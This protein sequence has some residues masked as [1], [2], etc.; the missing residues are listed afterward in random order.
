MVGKMMKKG[1]WLIAFL[2]VVLVGC[3]GPHCVVDPNWKTAPSSFTVVTTDPF[4]SNEGDVLDDFGGQ[5]GFRQWFAAYLDSAISVSSPLPHSVRVVDDRS[6]A[7]EP[8]Y[9]GNVMVK[10]P[11]LA[12][13]GRDSLSGVVLIVHPVQF[14]RE[15]PSCGGGT[16]IGD[17]RLH[18]Q[19]AY[20]I[21]SV[22]DRKILVHGIAHGSVSFHFAMTRGDWE[23]VVQ[24]V[25]W[26]LVDGTPLKN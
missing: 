14:R 7:M 15:M 12:N 19:V 2:A 26:S 23:K 1:G 20:S 16:C 8:M 17:K 5:E 22:E 24:Q 18:L 13:V 9:V 4:T 3:S 10:E 25:S 6:I 21:V 11:L